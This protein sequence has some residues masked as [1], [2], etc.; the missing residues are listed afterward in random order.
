MQSGNV[1]AETGLTAL[2]PSHPTPPAAPT[3][4]LLQGYFEPNLGQ[5][6][7]EVLYQWA[8]GNWQASFSKEGV[9]ID[10]QVEDTRFGF[11]F[12]GANPNLR[13]EPLERLPGISHYAAGSQEQWVL[14]VPH[15]DGLLFSDVWPGIDVKFYTSTDGYLEYDF[16][17]SPTADLGAVK[18]Q[19]H[20]AHLELDSTGA[21]SITHGTKTSTQRPPV[22]WEVGDQTVPVQVSYRLIGDSVFALSVPGRIPGAV[23]VVD[24]VVVPSYSTTY[25]A[26]SGGSTAAPQVIGVDIKVD[27]DGN[28]YITGQSWVAKFNNSGSELLYVTYIRDA[29]TA[30]ALDASGNVYVS[31]W[32]N[33]GFGRSGLCNYGVADTFGYIYKLAEKGSPF[34]FS[35]TF[36]TH[37]ASVFFHDVALDAEGNVYLTGS[38]DSAAWGK[39][40]T[41]AGAYDRSQ[42]SEGGDAIVMKLSPTL[43]VLYSTV[44]GGTGGGSTGQAI[45]VNSKG[46]AIVGGIT[47]SR[48]FPLVNNLEVPGA[49]HRG[50]ITRLSANGGSLNFS[51]LIGGEVRD[52]AVSPSDT[53]V[54]V[55]QAGDVPALNPIDHPDPL[56]STGV[57]GD[58]FV[59]QFSSSDELQFAS[60]LGGSGADWANGVA[61][62]ETGAIYVV[63]KTFS[64]DFPT[65]ATSMPSLREG[66]F[67]V[68]I[69]ASFQL[70]Y[71]TYLGKSGRSA[72]EA[73]KVTTAPAGLPFFGLDTTG[74][75]IVG[76]T[77]T[78]QTYP[79]SPFPSDDTD[80]KAFVTVLRTVI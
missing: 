23:L 15:F 28:Y 71:S 14:D 69:S 31:G 30:M 13:L 19:F 16:I 22:S 59:A 42:N 1:P 62:D 48:E 66:A 74:A 54:A 79:T 55:G 58:A 26:T 4:A 33:E 63:G 61:I 37:E 51:T 25:S 27:A 7:R 10:D 20:G 6:S 11:S 49:D 17:L 5:Y 43:A 45:G 32:T 64:V 78:D 72:A 75:Y 8:A 44:L 53:F 76:S 9:E 68:R 12:V 21:L 46:E 60:L 80:H 36:G 24:P 57:H 70:D 18:V 56:D 52:I 39:S 2:G 73:Q 50:F 77:Y 38:S 65:F 47:N 34:T 3:M 35:R 40:C 67:A 29:A 41:T